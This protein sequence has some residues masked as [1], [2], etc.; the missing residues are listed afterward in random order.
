MKL[1]YNFPD[2]REEAYR[3]AKE[4]QALPVKERLRD[5]LDTL[6]MGM[7]LLKVSPSREVIDRI[8]LERESRWQAIQKELF[9]RYGG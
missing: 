5:M 3:R 6:R 2:P 7:Y 1:P 9:R 8:F 4:F